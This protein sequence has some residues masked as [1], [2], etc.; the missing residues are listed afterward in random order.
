MRLIQFG[1]EYSTEDGLITL[2]IKQILS[3]YKEGKEIII[4]DQNGLDITIETFLNYIF[5]KTTKCDII[6]FIKEKVDEDE[7]DDMI[8]SDSF[9]IWNRKRRI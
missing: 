3:K 5:R 6:D 8:Y 2:N 1:D 7:L 9:E 4:E